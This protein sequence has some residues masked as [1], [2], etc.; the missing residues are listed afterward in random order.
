MHVCKASILA[1]S[2]ACWPG[3]AFGQTDLFGPE[4]IDV[5]I[6]LRASVVGGE[7]SWL[8]GGFG[9]LRY[10]GDGGETTPRA[11]VAAIDLAW[12][13]QISWNFSGLVSASYQD[14]LDGAPD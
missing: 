10:G 3:Q 11:R 5:A 8:E 4:N 9:K 14:Q 6:D 2:L 7:T 12:K 13:P 1:M